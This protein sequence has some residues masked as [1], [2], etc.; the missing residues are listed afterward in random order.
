MVILKKMGG[1]GGGG[2]GISYLNYEKC[3]K[4]YNSFSSQI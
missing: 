4:I 1:G 2:V 3:S